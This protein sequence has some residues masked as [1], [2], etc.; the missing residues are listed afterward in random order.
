MTVKVVF[1]GTPDFAVPS[2]HALVD[3]GYTIQCV[4][5]QPDR[6]KGRKRKITPPPVKVAAESLGLPAWQPE[7]ISRNEAVKKLLSLKPDVIVTAAFGQILPKAVLDAPRHGCINVHASLLPKY[8]G[9]APIHRAIMEGET[10]TGVTLMYM[11]EQ[12][13]AGDILTQCKVPIDKEDTVG[14]LHDKLSQAGAD[15]LRNSLPSI[16]NGEIEPKAQDER[17][18]TY[19][20]TIKREDE[21]IDWE[22]P[23]EAI[24]N[25]VRGLNPWPVAFTT[26][27]GKLLKVWRTEVVNTRATAAPPGSVTRVADGDLT[28]ATGKGE[29][30][31]LEVQPAGKKRMDVAQFL[32]GNALQPGTRL[33]DAHERS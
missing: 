33:G 23:A 3:L 10:E 24:H 31:L 28:V 18:A 13:D 27:G 29:L 26:C 17:L 15:L 8:R 32:R 14:T 30:R 19:A 1:M 4:V 22:M 12:L 5:T 16:L 21:R 25:H 11:V 9:G 20:P 6:P 7:K 2:L